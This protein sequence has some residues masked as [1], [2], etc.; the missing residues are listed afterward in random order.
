[1][2]QAGRGRQGPG[3]GGGREGPGQGGRLREGGGEIFELVV[4]PKKSFS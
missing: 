2:G 3:Q 1:M 4:S